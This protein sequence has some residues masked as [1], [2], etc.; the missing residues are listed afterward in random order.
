MEAE[1]TALAAAGATA[2]VQHMAADS[3]AQARDRLV[4]FLSRFSRHRVGEEDLIEGELETSR[5]ELTAALRSGDEQTALDV[6]AEWRTRLRRTLQA[7]PAAAAELRAVLDDLAP[8][9]NDQRDVNVHNTIS[10]GVY[11][12]PVIQTGILGSFNH[13]TP[14]DR[15]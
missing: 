2:F 14:P 9:G 4:S 6:E 1:L 11:H 7:N 13:G 12:A 3:W 5:S 15:V 10:G 8:G